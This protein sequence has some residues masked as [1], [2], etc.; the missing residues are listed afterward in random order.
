[1]RDRY[2]ALETRLIMKNGEAKIEDLTAMIDRKIGGL[3][4]ELAKWRAHRNHIVHAQKD[5]GILESETSPAIEPV[6]IAA[7]TTPETENKSGKYSGLGLTQAIKKLLREDKDHMYT[8][9][10]IRDELVAGGVDGSGKNFYVILGQTVKRLAENPNVVETDVSKG[11]KH[12]S[13]GKELL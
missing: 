3:E 9:P 10:V 2:S 13:A 4:E 11:K 5:L 8:I 1:V 12:Y 7:P 6:T